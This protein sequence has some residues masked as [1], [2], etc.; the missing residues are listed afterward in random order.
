MQLLL[1][2][3]RAPSRSN[4]LVPPRTAGRSGSRRREVRLHAMKTGG[5]SDLASLQ[6]FSAFP[7]GSAVALGKFDALHKGHGALAAA[8]CDMGESAWLMT[9]HGMAEVLG[10]PARM[11][12]V[13]PELRG[14]VLQELGV[15]ERS[16]PFSHIR[17]LAPEEFV[18]LLANVLRVKAIICGSNYRFGFRA[19]G[20]AQLLESLGVDAGIQV[21]VLDLLQDSNDV[22]CS[23]SVRDCLK[24]GDVQTVS[25]Y[26]G[27]PHVVVWERRE[28]NT[29]LNPSNQPPGDGTYEV[30]L[31]CS[32]Q[33]DKADAILN[34]REGVA[35]LDVSPS[36]LPNGDSLSVIFKSRKQYC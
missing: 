18:D 2:L 6:E 24:Q 20:D 21:R 13:A 30:Q 31:K 5:A 19:A 27:R 17:S 22:V 8:A 35:S 9:F 10:W 36:A 11:P 15:R 12:I 1:F 16:L 26:L 32:V 33:Q 25:R 23:S 34:I 7:R 14:S 4:F 28:G 3:L 29:L